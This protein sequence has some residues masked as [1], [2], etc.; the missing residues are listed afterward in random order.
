MA[1][2][3]ACLA[4]IGGT[5]ADLKFL[6]LPTKRARDRGEMAWMKA[7]AKAKATIIAAAADHLPLPPVS[8]PSSINNASLC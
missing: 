8:L 2:T 1:G 6:P 5:D 4:V 7:K 3:W